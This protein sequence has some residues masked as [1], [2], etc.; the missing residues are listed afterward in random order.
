[1]SGDLTRDAHV[2]HRR[3]SDGVVQRLDEHLR[4]VGLLSGR[5][6]AKF[7]LPSAG[8]LSGE[9]H[10][11]GKYSEEYKDYLDSVTGMGDADALRGKV[12]HSTAGAQYLWNARDPNNPVSLIAMQMLAL[13]VAS[14][15]S[16]LIDCLSPDGDDVFTR[17]MAKDDLKSHLTEIS[18]LLDPDIARR[19]SDPEAAGLLVAE[20]ASAIKSIVALESAQGTGKTVVQFK[21]G[22]LVRML[23]SGLLDA[24]RLDTADFERPYAKR[25]RNVGVKADWEALTARLESRLG[26]FGIRYPIDALRRDISDHCL[27][28]SERARGVFT[29]TVPT[30]GGKTLA[31]LRFA[32]AHAKRHGLERVIFVIPFT[33]IIDQNAD[34]ARDILEPKGVAPGSVVL[35]HHSN[36]APEEETYRTKLLSENWDAPVVFTTSVQLLESLFG[37]GTRSPRR[38]HQ[39]SKAVVVFDEVQSIPLRCTHLFNNA[40]NF[41]VEQA[42]SSVVLCTATQPLLNS[43]NPLKGAARFDAEDEIMPDAA[44]LFKTFKRVEIVSKVRPGGWCEDEVANLLAGEVREA[45][46]CLAIVN[47]RK[48]AV[49]LFEACQAIGLKELR[50]LSTSMCAAHRRAVLTD[51]RARLLAGE[52]MAC[53]STQL[54]ESGVDLDFG[55]CV[56]HVA[57]LDSIGH[58][59]GRCN[60]NGKRTLGRVHVINPASENIDRLVDIRIGRD[61]TLRVLGEYEADPAAFDHDLLSPKAMALYFGYYFFQRA[62]EMDYPVPPGVIGREDTLLNMLGANV[63]AEQDYRARHGRASPIFLR[64][65]FM[66]AARIFK[67]IDAP[68]QGVIVPYGEEGRALVAELKATEDMESLT[69]LLR[70]AQPFAVNV[71]PHVVEKLVK[72]KGF[73]D[74]RLDMGIYCLRPEFYSDDFGLCDEPVG[75]ESRL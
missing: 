60:R 49:A 2:A 7:G 73:S 20:V 41:L 56:R 16:G 71:F 6:G 57:G 69:R 72:N 12:D 22:L 62:Q 25:L 67:V 70:A 30:G 24:D 65:S 26:S 54:I 46:S 33:S 35:E 39:L 44:G 13:C 68:T 47:T 34:V 52:P 19:V 36:L 4:S 31:S 61:V 28:A 38:M 21:I 14:H 58:V 74:T 8:E 23:F 42:D 66:T 10:D 11:A 15:H 64:Q 18:K 75:V 1:M 50:H 40:I 32:M 45:G 53:V 27:A 51:V 37:S 59:A 3:A 43:V 48:N 9:M 29:L 55:A 5:H 17:R 63:F